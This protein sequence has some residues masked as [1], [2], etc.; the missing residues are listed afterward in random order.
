MKSNTD[1]L[2]MNKKKEKEQFWEAESEII[3]PHV[4]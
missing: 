3:N 1:H 4:F 2:N